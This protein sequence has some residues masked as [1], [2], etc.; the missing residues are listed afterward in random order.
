MRIDQTIWRP[1]SASKVRAPGAVATVSAVTIQRCETLR[2][3]RGS[4]LGPVAVATQRGTDAH[5]NLPPTGGVRGAGQLGLEMA[6][7]GYGPA[8]VVADLRCVT[9]HRQPASRES[10][11]V[12]IRNGP[13]APGETAMNRIQCQPSIT[14]EW[15]AAA[16][17]APDRRPA[18]TEAEL[19]L[20]P[21]LPRL[22]R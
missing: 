6:R 17:L 8:S 3:H 20:S 15:P 22:T 16:A 18:D 19:R 9:V 2:R 14:L 7:G 11:W 21:S 1:Q 10:G 4:A 5:Q 12:L 13:S